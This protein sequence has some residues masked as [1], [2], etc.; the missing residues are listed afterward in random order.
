[1]KIGLLK[2]GAVVADYQPTYGDFDSMFA[3]LF[4]RVMPGTELDVF[5]V[6]EGHYPESIDGYDGFVITGSADSVYDQEP[7]I[8]ELTAFVRKL[9]TSRVKTLGVCFGHQIIA[10]ALDGK[11]ELASVGWGVGIQRSSFRSVRPWLETSAETVGLLHSHRD[12]VT[13]LPT[14][15]EVYLTSSF[16]PNAG[17][18][19]DDHV[20]TVQGHPEFTRDYARTLMEHRRELLGDAY[21]PGIASLEGEV[22]DTA[23]GR[24]IAGF[25][26]A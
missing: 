8:G 4:E 19:I 21:E 23:V 24:W 12:Q 17:F 26:T 6:R 11:A 18:V 20:L 7:W 15:A 10:H 5:Y 25:F 3:T 2:A 22:D 1:M 16:C 14:G 13:T 9:V